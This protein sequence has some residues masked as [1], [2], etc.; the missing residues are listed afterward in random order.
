MAGHIHARNRVLER[1]IGVTAVASAAALLAG[2]GGIRA[3]AAFIPPLNTV[4]TPSY[5]TTTPANPTVAGAIPAD[6]ATI[7]SSPQS[8]NGNAAP[9][10]TK[11]F[12]GAV[13]NGSTT[14]YFFK[15]TSTRTDGSQT[16]LEDCAYA[17]GDPNNIKYAAQ[18]QNPPFSSGSVYTSLTVTSS[19]T[20]C[21]RVAITS[22]SGTDYTN[23]V[24]SG[25]G[26][27]NP[28]ACQQ[29]GVVPEAPAAG[30]IGLAGLGVA[31]GA[32]VVWRRRNLSLAT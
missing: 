15:I 25:G 27:A 3:A 24:G 16:L 1:L 13:P 10:A 32:A 17:N 8:L 9:F 7:L 31:G 19:D 14:T 20:I 12:A 11:T 6:C 30:L 29:G 28:S 23:L 5:T 4:P 21:D 22:P 2:P 18:A 26:Q